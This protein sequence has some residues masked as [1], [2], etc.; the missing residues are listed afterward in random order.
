MRR[1]IVVLVLAAAALVGTSTPVQAAPSAVAESSFN[2]ATGIVTT[3][4]TEA[5]TVNQSTALR[6]CPEY[7]S[8]Y[9]TMTS[10]TGAWGQIIQTY[11]YC[12]PH[13]RPVATNWTGSDAVKGWSGSSTW[14][15][16]STY[17]HSGSAS[18]TI[19]ARHEPTF[20]W[21]GTRVEW[22]NPYC[23]SPCWAEQ[24]GTLLTWSNVYGPTFRAWLVLD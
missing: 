6:A 2:F 18:G 7:R 23:L 11:L 21:W 10:P 22:P 15:R 1:L 12:G 24:D 17:I 8:K 13:V 3:V 9:V 4:H 19:V 14:G 16:P 5:V 20:I